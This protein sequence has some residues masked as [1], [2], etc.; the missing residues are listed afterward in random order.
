MKHQSDMNNGTGKYLKEQRPKLTHDALPS[1]G[2]Q[3][4]T[5]SV[6]SADDYKSKQMR[7]D[8]KSQY[9]RED[10]II[11]REVLQRESVDNHD[12]KSR[13]RLE[14]P[15]AARDQPRQSPERQDTLGAD[16]NE[17]MDNYVVLTKTKFDF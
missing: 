3:T 16:V 10:S 1:S 6:K 5:S 14:Q 17:D 8:R 11:T 9:S 13:G 2:S 7:Q 15:Q 4:L 12:V